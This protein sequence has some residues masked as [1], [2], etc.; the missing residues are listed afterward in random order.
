VFG[1]DAAV[2]SSTAAS[3]SP[4]PQDGEQPDVSATSPPL[5]FIILSIA[6]FSVFSLP[7]RVRSEVHPY[8]AAQHVQTTNNKKSMKLK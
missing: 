4:S 8:N 5:I 3:T 1:N 6:D 7:C 2:A